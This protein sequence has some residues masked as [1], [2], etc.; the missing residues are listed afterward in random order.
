MAKWKRMVTLKRIADALLLHP[1]VDL[2]EFRGNLRAA[3]ETVRDR[4]GGPVLVMGLVPAADP[5]SQHYRDR[6]E[7][8]FLEECARAGVRFLNI[9]EHWR[10]EG[11]DISYAHDPIHI[12]KRGHAW[13]APKLAAA[14]QLCLDEA[15]SSGG[16]TAPLAGSAGART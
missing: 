6:M 13:L 2:K 11:L 4:S 12:N 1:I 5:V 7:P 10:R 9:V 16:R 8:I 3:L 14:L 15:A